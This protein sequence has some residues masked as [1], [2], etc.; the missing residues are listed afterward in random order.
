MEP[1]DRTY[2]GPYIRG[3]IYTYIYRPH[4]FWSGHYEGFIL[5]RCLRF[6]LRLYMVYGANIYI[7]TYKGFL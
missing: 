7:Y 1:W 5:D 3:A 2:I 4:V 6:K